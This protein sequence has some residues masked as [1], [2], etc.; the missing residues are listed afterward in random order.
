MPRRGEAKLTEI[1][2]EGGLTQV[3]ASK[4]LANFGVICFNRRIT[5]GIEV[6]RISR[7]FLMSMTVYA[8]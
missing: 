3:D 4:N 5:E 8:V 1:I 2:K 7:A 6:C